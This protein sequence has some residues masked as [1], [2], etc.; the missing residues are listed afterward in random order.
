MIFENPINRPISAPSPDASFADS[1]CRRSHGRQS[2]HLVNSGTDPSNERFMARFSG[3]MT[4]VRPPADSHEHASISAPSKFSSTR[5]Q[6][7]S[8]ASFLTL[9]HQTV[10]GS[11]STDG[12]LGSYRIATAPEPNSSRLTSLKSTCFDSAMPRRSRWAST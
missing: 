1:G 4:L 7:T 3:V 11:A 10:W 8:P 6:P 12:Y 5:V 9:T 2:C